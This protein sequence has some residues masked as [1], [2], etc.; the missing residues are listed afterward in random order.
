MSRLA[1]GWYIPIRAQRTTPRTSKRQNPADKWGKKSRWKKH[2][3]ASGEESMTGARCVAQDF[4]PNGPVK[5]H[6]RPQRNMQWNQADFWLKIHRRARQFSTW[7]PPCGRAWHF[8]T[9]IGAFFTS[10]NLAKSSGRALK[11]KVASRE[12]SCGLHVKVEHSVHGWAWSIYCQWKCQGVVKTPHCVGQ[13][14]FAISIEFC[15]HGC[16]CRRPKL[17]EHTNQKSRPSR[18]IRTK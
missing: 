17:R 2:C 12:R 13:W 8:S 10:E 1:L 15:R 6:L 16:R 7:K 9:E 14:Y 18:Q 4:R 3:C 5:Y 11:V